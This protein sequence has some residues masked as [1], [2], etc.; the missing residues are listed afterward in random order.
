MAL[1]LSVYTICTNSNIIETKSTNLYGSSSGS[2]TK[3]IN[4]AASFITQAKGQLNNLRPGIANA[5]VAEE[6]SSRY[7]QILYEK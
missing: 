5:V 4:L 7:I 2:R 6:N 1:G 3:S